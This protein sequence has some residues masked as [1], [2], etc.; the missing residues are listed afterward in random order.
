MIIAEGQTKKG[1]LR[2]G[3]SVTKESL[4]E[5]GN[6]FMVVEEDFWCKTEMMKRRLSV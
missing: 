6:E 2:L 1:N 3:G 4:Y 5:L